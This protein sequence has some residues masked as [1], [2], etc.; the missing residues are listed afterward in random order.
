MKRGKPFKKGRIPW[1]KGKSGYNISRK[2]QKH[3]QKTKD[4]MS[5]KR[6][7]NPI[8]YWLG[9]KKSEETKRKMSDNR[10]NKM[11][12]K[13]HW[14][15]KGGISKIDKLCRDMPEYKQWRSNIF[16]RDNWTCQTCG[17]R[18]GKYKTAHHIISFSKIIKQYNI[19][20]IKQARRCK[21]LWDIN[22]G[23][24]LCEECHSLTDNYKGRA[25]KEIK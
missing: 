2:G 9:K 15:W 19:L 16:T 21:E 13:N 11:M 14:N 8:R 23:V 20:N 7:E 17:E 25:R 12:G 10:K 5:K 3:S 4:K 1:N 24:T 22:N 6:K 18:D